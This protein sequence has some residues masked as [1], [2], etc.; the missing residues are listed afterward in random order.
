M[1]KELQHRNSSTSIWS[2]PVRSVWTALAVGTLFLSAVTTAR[3]QEEK[4]PKPPTYTVLYTFTGGADG[5][6]PNE[7]HACFRRVPVDSDTGGAEG[8]IYAGIGKGQC[9]AGY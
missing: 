3:S 1:T 4:A 6:F 9:W 2:I 8:G 5:A 7:R